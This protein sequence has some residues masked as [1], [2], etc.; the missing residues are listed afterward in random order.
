M[1]FVTT[2][3]ERL[4]RYRGAWLALG[5]VMVGVVAIGS[6]WPNVPQVTSGMSDK[7]LH[8]AAYA[9]LA[10]MFAGV[11]ERSHWGRVL[12]GLLLFGAGIELAQA[13]LSS[14]RSGEWLDLAANAG[15]VAAGLLTAALFP[16]SWCREIEIVAGLEGTSR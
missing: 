10:F 8:F 4:P 15:G 13:Y 6:L 5:W 11:V 3:S 7:L 14:T 9:G 12:V 1:S 16:R 2:D